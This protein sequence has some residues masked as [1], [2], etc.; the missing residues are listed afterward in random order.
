MLS[1]FLLPCLQENGRPGRYIVFK[2]ELQRNIKQKPFKSKIHFFPL[3]PNTQT[4]LALSRHW[5]VGNLSN[6]RFGPYIFFFII[7]PNL[8]NFVKSRCSS[9][10]IFKLICAYNMSSFFK[11][12]KRF[13][14]RSKYM[15]QN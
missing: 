6:G 5:Y 13:V 12:K 11:N 7:C 15:K 3:H 8:G 2:K 9:F 4:T 14:K 1:K 10:L